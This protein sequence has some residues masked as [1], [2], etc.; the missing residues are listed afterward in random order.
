MLHLLENLSGFFSCDLA[1]DLGSTNTL[2]YR[3][4]SGIIVNEPSILAIERRSRDTRRVIGAGA[5]AREQLSRRPDDVVL[6]KPVKGGIV[7]DFP[8]AREMLVRYLER[9][10]SA[11]FRGPL[12]VIANA[13]AEAS[14]KEKAAIRDLILSAGAREVYLMEEPRA[15]ALGAGLDF[16]EETCSMVVD[17][18]GGITEMA[19]IAEGRVIR[20][21]SI[22]AGGEQMDRKIAAYV[23]KQ[24]RLRIS[25]QN[26]EEI[27]IR[28]GDV[29][30]ASKDVSVGVTGYHIVAEKTG[31]VHINAHEVCE[32]LSETVRTIVKAV[33]EFLRTLSPQQ[34]VDII[35]RGIVLAGGGSLLRNMDR[36]LERE[37]L[38]PVTKVSDPL[39][40]LVRGS[41]DALDYLDQ[42]RREDR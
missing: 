42:F 10:R 6:V 8:A 40:C 28:V 3:K 32:A 26:A 30:P 33:K 24:H 38:Y 4:G 15:L 12:R 25:L 19:A 11:W 20:T 16:S 5:Q 22:P 17:I 9:A 27:K 13:P 21:R 14:R 34:A 1:I 39:T 31:S 29:C 37:L 7:S 41:G 36:L 23:E 2:I 35:D 18:G